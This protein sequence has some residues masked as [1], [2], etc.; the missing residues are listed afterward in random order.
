MPTRFRYP[1]GVRPLLIEEAARR[2]AI[3]K[4]VVE[5]L[6]GAGYDEV[7][8]PIIDFVDPYTAIL[9]REVA[10]QSYRFVDR[11]GELVAIRSDFTPILACALAPATTDADL[12]LR[13]FYLV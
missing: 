8:R 2:R 9:D 7:V 12:P 4:R 1:T 6:G 11:D 10:R 5:R 3:E 13:V